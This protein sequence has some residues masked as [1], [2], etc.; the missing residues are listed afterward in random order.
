RR[1]P[2]ALD[3]LG[4][5]KREGGRPTASAAAIIGNLSPGADRKVPPSKP[6]WKALLLVDGHVVGKDIRQLRPNIE[7][8]NYVKVG[9]NLHVINPSSAPIPPGYE[10]LI[11]DVEPVA[12]LHLAMA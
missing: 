9:D 11:I 10:E 6:G 1:V 8:K 4:Y 3:A 2:S 5:P 7:L 12:L